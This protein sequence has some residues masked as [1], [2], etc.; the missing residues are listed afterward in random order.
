MREETWRQLWTRLVNK[1]IT[2]T[3]SP[4]TVRQHDTLA[5][6]LTH[7]GI[8][9]VSRT[10]STDSGV[11][12]RL[13]LLQIVR[14]ARILPLSSDCEGWEFWCLLPRLDVPHFLQHLQITFYDCSQ[15][16]SV[17]L[18]EQFTLVLQQCLPCGTF[19]SAGLS[20]PHSTHRHLLSLKAS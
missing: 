13:E 19:V 11:R 18:G 3:A 6:W 1:Y 2:V 7:K 4:A 17:D 15:V 8:T 9:A 5:H 14:N 16:F 10:D 12:R 20:L